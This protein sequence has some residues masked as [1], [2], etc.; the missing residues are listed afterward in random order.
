M[1]FSKKKL[2]LALAAIIVIGIVCI[3]LFK[4]TISDAV[5]DRVVKAKVG[6]DAAASLP[7]GLHVGLCG[8]GSPLPNPKR[9]EAC[10]IIIAGQRMYVVDIGDAAPR[11]IVFMGLLPG[12][13]DGLFLTH[14]HSDH[15]N[16]MGALMLMRWTGSSH[17]S[18]LP[19]YG[20]IGVDRVISGFNAAY[21]LDYGYRT[22][23]H[24][25]EIVPQSGAGAI[26]VPFSFG[27]N[28]PAESVVVLEKD[29][30]KVTAFRV[31]HGPIEPSVGYR[32]DYK[33]RS[34]VLS[35]DTSK[36]E[37]LTSIARD[38]D[39]LVHEAIAPKLVNKMTTALAAKN[40]DNTAQITRDILNYHTTPVEAAQTAASA[41]VRQLVLSHIAPAIPSRFFYPSFLD[42]AKNHFTGPIVVGEDGMLFSLSARTNQITQ[43]QLIK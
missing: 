32:F 37:V 12:K 3:N 23:H 43:T 39:I 40:I 38:A 29:G 41:N 30:L 5:I 28:S 19:V 21:Q 36:S 13:I 31:N 9:A 26:A 15:I 8:T 27:A 4:V 22:A 25:E 18:P 17:K 10:N 20:P 6:Q 1:V 42:G 11:N 34:I 16:G 33:G 2:F 14:F 7:D 35:G 24:G